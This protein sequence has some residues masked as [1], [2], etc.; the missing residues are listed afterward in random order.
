MTLLI[1][2]LWFN[3]SVLG[4]L[5]LVALARGQLIPVRVRRAVS[6]PDG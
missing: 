3:T 4:P 2:S 6:R 1:A 5:P